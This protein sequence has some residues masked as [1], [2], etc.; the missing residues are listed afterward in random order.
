M[1]K[2]YTMMQQSHYNMNGY[3]KCTRS[4]KWALPFTQIHS[5][6]KICQQP[7]SKACSIYCCICTLSSNQVCAANFLEQLVLIV[8]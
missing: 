6:V 5:Q 4:Q 1:H 2:P 7:N 8:V 3:Y